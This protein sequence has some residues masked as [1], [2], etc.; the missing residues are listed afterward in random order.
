ML[1][2]ITMR[3]HLLNLKAVLPILI[4]EVIRGFF[5]C[6]NT[7]F[8]CIVPCYGGVYMP[9]N[10][11]I[12]TNASYFDHGIIGSCFEKSTA[13]LKTSCKI[14]DINYG[15]LH[16]TSDQ[17]TTRWKIIVHTLAVDGKNSWTLNA[18]DG[19]EFIHFLQVHN[20]QA[21]DHPAPTAVQDSGVPQVLCKCIAGL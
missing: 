10:F 19:L 4:Q 8:G 11:S 16:V 18:K 20:V 1:P 13:S 3:Y 2:S 7:T 17:N 14:T 21:G 9:Q 15:P 6:V 12:C 5:E